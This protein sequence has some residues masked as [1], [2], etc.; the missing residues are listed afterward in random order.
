MSSLPPPPVVAGEEQLSRRASRLTSALSLVRSI[1]YTHT[2]SHAADSE[3]GPSR[4]RQLHSSHNS[5]THVPAHAHFDIPDVHD[6][7]QHRSGLAT[8][9]S[10]SYHT[11]GPSGQ[12]VSSGDRALVTETPKQAASREKR[13]K[14]ENRAREKKQKSL[15]DIEHVPVD[16]DPR[17]WSAGKKNIV[18]I[19][20]IM[21]L[22]SLI[23]P[24]IPLI[25]FCCHL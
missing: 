3:A 1:E 4:P 21:A 24:A 7:Q 17:K 20:I 23:V 22:V 11:A 14:R 25:V 9:H 19:M 13:E 18:L 10:H 16:D 12:C 6:E 8:P 5:R 2:D 15:I